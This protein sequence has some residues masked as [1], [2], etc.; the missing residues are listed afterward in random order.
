[1]ALS[2][3]FNVH[4]HT[5][6]QFNDKEP[7]QVKN[8]KQFNQWFRKKK[9]FY[10]KSD[11]VNKI[12]IWDKSDYSER[13]NTSINNLPVIKLTNKRYQKCNNVVTSALKRKLHLFQNYIVCLKFTTQANLTDQSSDL[14][15][16]F[17]DL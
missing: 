15:C 12:I 10:L 6:N 9:I 8:G 13:F 2:N 7:K 16:R 17:S 11:K 4:F 3:S 5:S 14:S 1:M